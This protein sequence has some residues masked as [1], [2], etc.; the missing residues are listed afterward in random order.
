MK[1]NANIEYNESEV[2]MENKI[3]HV[4]TICLVICCLPGPAASAENTELSR[5]TT[6]VRSSVGRRPNVPRTGVRQVDT[7]AINVLKTGQFTPDAY[8]GSVA[9]A[10]FPNGDIFAAYAKERGRGQNKYY[11]EA[12][13]YTRQMQKKWAGTVF[14]Q[15]RSVGGLFDQEAVVFSGGNIL[16]AYSEKTVGGKGQGKFV[17]LNSAGRVVGSPQ[18]L[19][20]D[21][22]DEMSV[23]LLAGDNTA[24]IAY[25]TKRGVSGAG[26]FVVVNSSGK[27]LVQPG[28]FSSKGLTPRLS[29][30]A[31]PNGLVFL[32][33]QCGRAYSKVIDV[34]GGDV[35]AEKAFHHRNP[36]TIDARPLGNGSVLVV[37]CVDGA[38]Y[39]AV[40]GQDGAVRGSPA[41]F[42]GQAAVGSAAVAP[43]SGERSLIAFTSTTSGIQGTSSILCVVVDS[44]GQ[45]LKGPKD[46]TP[47]GWILVLNEGFDA[48]LLPG[49][50][51]LVTYTKQDNANNPRDRKYVAAYVIVK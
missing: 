35:R 21:H 5:K 8:T 50:N 43:L 11:S 45:V 25:S 1:S 29:V 20:S 24:L 26:K 41:K 40:L 14:T 9:V 47:Q 48:V 22:V 39:T 4:M 27:I 2:A 38:G 32:A 13:L 44:A 33:Y 12:M 16:V 51:V 42:Y 28:T 10:A 31:M 19:G 46:L 34:F 7:S 17:V 15:D 36:S 49:D 37:Y 3:L 30:H 23:T 18:S 6:N